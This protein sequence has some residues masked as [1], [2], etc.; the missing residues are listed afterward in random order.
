MITA[1]GL[2]K[3]YGRKEVLRGLSLVA[4][5]GEIT[6]LVG[7]NGA[8]K[9]TTMKILGGLATPDDGRVSVARHD[10]V[11]AKLPAQRALSIRRRTPTFI[12]ASPVRS[13]CAFMRNSGE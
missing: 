8:G 7:E 4:R 6:L 13:C 2:T 1:T 5:P 3:S 10:I 12:P 9:S 11:K